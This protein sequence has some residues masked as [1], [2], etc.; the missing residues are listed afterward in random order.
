MK[1]MIRPTKGK[2][3]IDLANSFPPE[4]EGCPTGRIVRN[5]KA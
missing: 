3:A 2:K 1:P 5:E 4:R